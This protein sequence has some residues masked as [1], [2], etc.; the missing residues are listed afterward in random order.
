M[1]PEEE[2]PRREPG[3]DSKSRREPM[4]VEYITS[5]EVGYLITNFDIGK[6]KLKASARSAANWPTLIN[7]LS[8]AGS[9]WEIVGLSDC[10]GDDTL[11]TSI[12][13]QRADAVRA[14]LPAAAHV[15]SS[16]GAKLHDCITGNDNRTARQ[17]NRAVLV[18]QTV[19]PVDFP[20]EVLEVKDP[21]EKA[22]TEDCDKPQRD[23]LARALPLAKKMVRAA[24]D[25]L[26][27]KHLLRKYFGKD[28]FAHRFHIKQNFVAIKNGLNGGPIFECE[29]A[30]SWLCEGSVAYVIG[31]FGENIHLCA[32]AFTKDID[33]LAR[34][35]VHEAAH[36]YAWVFFPDTLCTGG[37]PSSM[38][39]TDAEDN[40]DSY[41]E[42]A[43]DALAKS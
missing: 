22:N 15:V 10:H 32:Q 11:N 37:C 2:C 4:L 14:A 1:A 16:S 39:T 6:S 33:F 30:D 24:L 36:G 31:P 27:D 9:Q 8:K 21:A 41:G 13:Q 40:A 43:G 7:A 25:A 42:F 23:A 28:A 19:T 38:D 12:R 5:P 20:G 3:E 34:T 35:I 26:D 29:E 18:R 17:W